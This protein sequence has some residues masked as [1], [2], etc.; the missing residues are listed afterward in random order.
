[1]FVLGRI[2][3]AVL[4]DPKRFVLGPIW[5]VCTFVFVCFASVA[6][7]IVAVLIADFIGGGGGSRAWPYN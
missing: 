5:L 4:Q 7:F 2:I 6:L 1:M 3:R